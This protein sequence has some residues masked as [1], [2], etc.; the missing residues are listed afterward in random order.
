MTQH[1]TPHRTHGGSSDDQRV[2]NGRHA[3]VAG[4]P[5]QL[6][7]EL[8]GVLDALPAA[9]Y[10]TDAQGRLTSY[11]EAAADMWGRR[12]ELGERWCGSHRLYHP[13]GRPMPK[14]ECPLAIAI[15][16]GRDV[17]GMELVIERADG[18]RRTALPFPTLLRDASGR[19]TGAVNLVVDITESQ[20]IRE[21]RRA[22]EERYRAIV[23]TQSELVC[24]FRMDGTILFVNE[25]YARARGLRREDL[26]GKNLWEF[27][28]GADHK[29]V[30]AELEQIT[31]DRPELVIE[32]SCET[33]AGP[34]LFMWTNR[35]LSFDEHGRPVELQSSGV[36][37]TDRTLAE[38]ALRE[39]ERR[40]RVLADNIS[41]FAWMADADGSLNWYNRRWYE[42]T[43][44]NFE[45]MQGWGWRAVQHPDHVDRVAERWTIACRDGQAWEDTFPLR[46][47]DGQYRWFLSRAVPIRDA[48]G[49][50]IQWFGTNTDITEQRV[51]EEELD[52]HRAD[53]EARVQERT[54]E[55]RET[56]ERLRMSERMAMMGT[57]SAGLGH[58]MGNLLLPVRVRLESLASQPLSDQ[59]RE[60]VEAIR[61]S[62]EYLR[63]LAS[64]LRLL[65][66][67]P[68]R[69]VAAETS[70]LRAWWA[71]VEGLLKSAT[72]RGV[73]LEARL[74]DRV[75]RVPISA[76]ALTQVVF[77]LVQNAGD[78]LRERGS[79]AIVIEP[80]EDDGEVCVIVSDD[81]PGMAPEV[82]E[83]CMEPY[84]STKT[85]GISTGLG[86]AL[87]HGLVREAGGR[88]EAQ[89]RPGEGARFT[90][91]FPI[92]ARHAP[93]D[94][95]T[96]P[97][98]IID[99][100]DSR[101]RS[102]TTRELRAIDVRIEGAA[103]GAAGAALFVTD[104][105]EK[106]LGA[107]EDAVLLL[108]AD[109]PR[110]CSRPVRSLGPR[111]EFGALRETLRDIFKDH[112]PPAVPARGADI[113]HDR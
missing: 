19:V 16:E 24:R 78:A 27:V 39:S 113:I 35:A 33:A 64:G 20:T 93:S 3:P 76:A 55:L 14:D 111:P 41:Q 36:D 107:P 8:A 63:R 102:L 66:L 45:Q 34:R 10:T 4:L 99:V 17:R 2:P 47:K 50:V 86:L 108:F 82:L 48:Q 81:G 53:L 71:D 21:T 52:R 106:L 91:R 30:R 79:G 46:G 13:D 32:N 68:H 112:A 59:A 95:R 5:S 84:F 74:D 83:R 62:A 26:E 1:A 77:N 22:A 89:S 98:A 28:I 85:R 101:L 65:A 88:L 61:T 6:A 105:P 92:P 29:R 87:V 97:L 104:D 110:G 23:D 57:L 103:T 73:T 51:V 43:G 90:L 37:I 18:L 25:A 44:T 94:R 109:A 67:D 80:R 49:R 60:D 100:R 42:Y 7:P 58:D 70:D 56:Y 12:P 15:R 72:P 31:I 38:R 96:Q 11:N 40:F 9:I 54:R 69:S 75:R